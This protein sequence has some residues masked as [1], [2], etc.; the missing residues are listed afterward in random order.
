MRSLHFL[1]WQVSE[2]GRQKGEMAEALSHKFIASLG[3]S[4]QVTCDHCWSLVWQYGGWGGG[5]EV[6]GTAASCACY[7]P[8]AWQVAELGR[9]KTARQ[10]LSGDMQS[11]LVTGVAV[12]GML[13]GG[14]GGAEESEAQTHHALTA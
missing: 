7:F 1:V 3:C 5:G 9:Q 4:S 8:L 2:L 11:L 10:R 6:R 12:R 13:G 14:G